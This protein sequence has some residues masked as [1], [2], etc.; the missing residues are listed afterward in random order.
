MLGAHLAGISLDTEDDDAD[1]GG[2]FGLTA[3]WG[4]SNGLSI[5]LNGTVA[6]MEPDDDEA[7]NYIL[8][9]GEL[10]LRYTFGSSAARWRPY[11]NGAL[12]GVTATFENVEFGDLGRADVEVSGPV[13]SVGGGVQFFP[14]A[15]LAIDGALAWGGGEFDEVKVDN[16]TVDLD[17]SDKIKL[18]LFRLQLGL[19][20]YFSKPR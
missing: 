5:F 9:E 6:N 1:G 2:G 4:F 11:L 17:D 7:D 3:G 15:Q 13:F 19:R 20:Y 10:G 18:T 8:G 14:T 12:G 16:V